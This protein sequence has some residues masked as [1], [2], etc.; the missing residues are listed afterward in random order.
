MRKDLNCVEIGE[1]YK[2]FTEYHVLRNKA[3]ELAT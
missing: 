3:L 2:I 1:I